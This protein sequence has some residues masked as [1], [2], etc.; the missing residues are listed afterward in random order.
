MTV[1]EL[2]QVL[3]CYHPDAE[4]RLLNTTGV[5]LPGIMVQANGSCVYLFNCAEI[6]IQTDKRNRLKI[7]PLEY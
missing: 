2:V 6:D 1:S 3:R 5:A 7:A 4:I